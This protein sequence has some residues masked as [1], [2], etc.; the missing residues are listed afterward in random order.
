MLIVFMDFEHDIPRVEPMTGFPPLPLLSSCDKARA[1]GGCDC[2]DVGVVYH[3][4][5]QRLHQSLAD[6]LVGTQ[7]G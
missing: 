5:P 3:R 6:R 2:F 4:C 7:S 1:P